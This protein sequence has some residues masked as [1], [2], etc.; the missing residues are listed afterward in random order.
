MMAV[1]IMMMVVIVTVI[2]MVIA[3]G[4][5]GLRFWDPGNSQFIWE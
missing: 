3:T 2:V 4:V 1:L 5:A